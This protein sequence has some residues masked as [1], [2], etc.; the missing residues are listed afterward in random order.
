LTRSSS[1]P[2]L[3][4]ALPAGPRGD[5][6]GRAHPGLAAT[7]E[8]SMLE[9]KTVPS[10]TYEAS[11]PAA[12]RPTAR[13]RSASRARLEELLAHAD[14]AIDGDRPWDPQIRDERFFDIAF[15]GSLAIGEAYMD[16]LWECAQLDEL[17]CRFRRASLDERFRIGADGWRALKAR[18]RNR[19][20]PSRAYHMGHRVYDG[21]IDLFEATLDPRMV[22]SCGYW[23]TATTLAAAQEAKLELACRK[24]GLAPGMRVL[25]V[26]C[27]W[28]S[29]V[30]YAAEH[31]GVE[32]VGVT[33][34][35]E[36]MA[37]GQKRCQGLPVEI[38]F[39]DYRDVTGSFDRVFSAGMFEHVGP[40]NHRRYFETVHRVLAR[41]GLFLLHTVGGNRSLPSVDAWIDKYIFPDAVMPSASQI[42][43]AAERLFVIEDWHTFGPDYDKTLLAWFQ[44]FERNWPELRGHY[45]ERFYRIWKF[46]LLACAGT[47][48]AR[49]NHLWHFV[50]SKKGLVGGYQAV[51]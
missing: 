25:D 1:S 13:D 16:G 50:F 32:A 39:Q 38:R 29:F 14:I 19:Q 51:R 37:Y 18:L 9:A 11:K 35:K 30:H 47:F 27:G 22:Y 6:F 7:H 23:K 17:V 4:A 8:D 40:R 36:Q 3:W 44:N 2:R 49:I 10:D 48:R 26:G 31:Y 45:D 12:P 46:Y 28:G 21:A 43:R 33:V 15:G 34:S 24:L 42:A 5:I 41:D 20:S